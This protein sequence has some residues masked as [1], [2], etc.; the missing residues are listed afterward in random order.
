[1]ID[2]LTW[3]VAGLL[4]AAAGAVALALGMRHRRVR[5]QPTFPP[6]RPRRVQRRVERTTAW[7]HGDDEATAVLPSIE[8][9]R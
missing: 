8:E 2:V 3:P 9:Q 7:E 1:M 4:L 5:R 6:Y